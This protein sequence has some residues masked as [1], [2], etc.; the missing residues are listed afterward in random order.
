MN[1]HMNFKRI[2]ADRTRE[3]ERNFPPSILWKALS[4]F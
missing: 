2:D 4:C 1:N 3:G